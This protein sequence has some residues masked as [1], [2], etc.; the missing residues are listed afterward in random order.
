MK[1]DQ[2]IELTI[3]GIIEYSDKK[4]VPYDVFIWNLFHSGDIEKLSFKEF[5]ELIN[6]INKNGRIKR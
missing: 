2:I 1:I 4:E 6:K 3:T 5:R